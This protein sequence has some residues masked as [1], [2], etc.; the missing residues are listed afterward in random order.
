MVYRSSLSSL[1]ND[2]AVKLSS[3]WSGEFGQMMAAEPGAEPSRKGKN[4][5]TGLEP[6]APDA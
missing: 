3:Q 2:V 4:A 6:G 5:Q 1:F